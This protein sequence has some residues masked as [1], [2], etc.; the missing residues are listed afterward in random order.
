M[1]TPI[2]LPPP[3]VP[4]P[5]DDTDSWDVVDQGSWESFP[6]SDPPSWGSA[7]AA[8]S[9]RS[10]AQANHEVTSALVAQ[11]RRRRLLISAIASAVTLVCGLAGFF[12]Y[13]RR[14]RSP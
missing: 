4:H 2:D 11:R 7:R 9:R 13:K 14:V 1:S 6:A 10:V 5:R 3:S 8:P 12:V